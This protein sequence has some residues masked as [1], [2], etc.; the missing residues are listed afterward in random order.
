MFC[1]WAGCLAGCNDTT[2][3]NPVHAAVIRIA[4]KT[5][6]TARLELPNKVEWADFSRVL[7]VEH[8]MQAAPGCVG[9]NMLHKPWHAARNS[10][11]N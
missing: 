5:A 4:C 3:Q 1:W 10:K 8:T 9:F 11:T 6:V 2:M 7:M